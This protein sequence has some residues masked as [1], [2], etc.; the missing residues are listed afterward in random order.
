MT[1]F[2]VLLLLIGG[3][4]GLAP[5]SGGGE[6]I[7]VLEG[8]GTGQWGSPG[9]SA[10]FVWRYETVAWSGRSRHPFHRM[11]TELEIVYDPDRGQ[12]IA[13]RVVSGGDVRGYRH[14]TLT[15]ENSVLTL[16]IGT[17]LDPRVED[18]T[19]VTVGEG[20]KNIGV[21]PTAGL[22]EGFQV[23]F[24]EGSFRVLPGTG[25]HLAGANVRVERRMTR[26]PRGTDPVTEGFP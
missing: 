11:I 12:V 21:G 6:E 22:V 18:R 16:R 10:N 5:G 20:P 9:S 7:V 2:F 26:G 4:A 25:A 15:P 23:R 1:G 8:A 19:V 24:A 14:I 13:A 17:L 3:C